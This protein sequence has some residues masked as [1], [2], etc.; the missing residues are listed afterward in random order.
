MANSHA[1]TAEDLAFRFTLAVLAEAA[2]REAGAA[3]MAR[4]RRAPSGVEE[5]ST[6]TDPV[7]DADREADAIIQAHISKAR[8]GDVFLTE[9]SGAVGDAGDVR[10]V[11]DPLDGTVNYLYGIANWAVSIAA[12][13]EG[14]VVA[15]V[16]YQAAIDECFVAVRDGGATL[17][18]NAIHVSTCETL[19]RA[20]LGT[21]FDYAAATRAKQA[22]VVAALMPKCRDIR[23]MGAASID[24]ASVAA[25]RL[26]GYF[27]APHGGP[28]DW[29]AGELLVEEAGGKCR[30]YAPPWAPKRGALASNGRLFDALSAAVDAESR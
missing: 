5:K 13:R 12:E 20:L 8:P 28:W 6:A 10:W 7:S 30:P 16:V 9:E 3:L 17:N 27:E 4:F 15:G 26:D 11:V 22:E 21:G 19:D 23:R 2:A 1:A 14:R 18:G 24:L 29:A 25:G